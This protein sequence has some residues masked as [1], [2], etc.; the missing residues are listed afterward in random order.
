[1]KLLINQIL[2]FLSDIIHG[3]KGKGLQLHGYKNVVIDLKPHIWR[4][5]KKLFLCLN[6]EMGLS[7][8]NPSMKGS[9]WLGMVVELRVQYYR[10][11]Y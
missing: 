6:F 7:N 1:M 4:E 11:M 8:T 9:G 5:R 2:T 10:V 3:Y